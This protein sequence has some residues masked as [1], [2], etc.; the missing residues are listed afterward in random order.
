VTTAVATG[1]EP[2]TGGRPPRGKVSKTFLVLGELMITFGIVVFLFIFYELVVTN[3]KTAAAQHR[4]EH[5]LEQQWKQPAPKP[6]TT[7][8]TTPTQTNPTPK[9]NTPAKPAI[10]T[11][12]PLALTEGQGFAI[13]RIPR[14]GDG[15]HWVIVEG[16]S[17]DD[18]EEG[19]GHYPGTAQPGQLGNF[20]VSGHRTTYGAPFNRLGELRPGDLITIQTRYRTWKYKVLDTKIV[21][22]SATWTIFPVPGQLGAVPTKRLMTMTTCNPEYSAA[23]RMIVTSELVGST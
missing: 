22:P 17:H 18:L 21:D 13:V 15:Y 12:P 4:L 14:L 11:D 10:A 8:P 20:V 7:T 9:T 2:S 16:V 1:V 23:Q 5:Q 3:W 6:S 19:P